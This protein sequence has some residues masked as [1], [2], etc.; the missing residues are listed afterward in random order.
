MARLHSELTPGIVYS[1]EHHLLAPLMPRAQ[2]SAAARNAWRS[3]GLLRVD[4]CLVAAMSTGR[5]LVASIVDNARTRNVRV[6]A[7]P[8]RCSC[9]LCM[10]SWLQMS[11]A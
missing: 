11:G 4:R 8:R 3:A 1:D 7:F 2:G 6:S 10:I 5:T 9:V